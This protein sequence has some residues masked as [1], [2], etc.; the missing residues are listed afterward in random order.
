MFD[1]YS[2]LAEEVISGLAVKPNGTYID[3]T[4]GSGG[5]AEKIASQLND[6]GLLVAFDQ[7]IDALNAAKNR[8]APYLERIIFIHANFRELKNVLQEYQIKH[9]DGVLFDLG[10]SS[11]QL[12]RK[13]R[14]FSYQHEGNLDMRMNRQEG[15]IDAY[16][17]VNTW[18]YG[19]LVNI[20]FKYGEEKFSKQIARKIVS[21]RE[22]QSIQTTYE[23]VDII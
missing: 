23:L 15:I 3:C 22:K 16:E 14:G 8:L 18:T 7:D 6:G 20:F 5:H 11:P 17:I 21:E 2:V 13:E 1:H 19:A 10:V 9:I 12:D 4:L